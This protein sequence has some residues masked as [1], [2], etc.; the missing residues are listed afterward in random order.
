MGNAVTFL[1]KE[2]QSCQPILDVGVGTGRFAVPLQAAGLRIVGVDVSAKML[3]AAATKGLRE[4]MRCEAGNLSCRDG[5]FGAALMV[6]FLH[7]TPFWQRTLHEV[8]RVT[9][10]TICSL[11]ASPRLPFGPTYA[12]K[13]EELGYRAPRRGIRE[14][15]LAKLLPP[16]NTKF[17]SE[18]REEVDTAEML[19][20]IQTRTYS[21][22]WG[23]PEPLHQAA[24]NR[25]RAE[26]RERTM[27]F[28]RRL[29]YLSWT[30]GSVKRALITGALST[31]RS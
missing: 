30:V 16:S 29:T 27:I 19:R 10:S 6:H 7:L 28:S 4:T 20:L 21:Q 25:L 3:K 31:E 5:Y 1:A 22:Q 24:T 13:L 18:F 15:E 14:E 26:F 2:L 17:V 9:D 12:R 11:Y 8:C 23:V